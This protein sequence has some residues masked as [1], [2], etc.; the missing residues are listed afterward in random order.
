MGLTE[1][2]SSQQLNNEERIE[3][4]KK[5]T[6]PPVS[7]LK[8]MIDDLYTKEKKYVKHYV[9]EDFIE[10]NNFIFELNKVH[11]LGTSDFIKDPHIARKRAMK[12]TDIFIG[13]QQ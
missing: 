11:N 3:F 1:N 10:K 7:K 13:A 12:A 9:R 8:N 6:L 4:T 2:P 5:L